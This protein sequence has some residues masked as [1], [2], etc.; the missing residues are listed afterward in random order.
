MST[1][2]VERSVT[3]KAPVEKAFRVFTERFAT[4][5]PTSHSINPQGYAA[6]F[7][8]AREGGRWY[9]RAPDGSEQDWGRVL[10]WEPPHRLVLSWQLD[11]DYSYDPDPAHASEVEITF[12]AEGADQTRVDLVHSGFERQAKP[13]SVAGSVGNEGGWNGLLL[14]FGD[15]VEGRE[16]RALSAA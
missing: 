12:T 7:I 15:A 10:T 9:E 3:V 14:R 5:W 4:W 1:L 6:A 2:A 8:E 11:G 16:I 13:E